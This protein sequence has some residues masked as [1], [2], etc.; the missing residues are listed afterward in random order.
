MEI[1]P[2]DEKDEVVEDEA[3]WCGRVAEG[4]DIGWGEME[5]MG[6]TLTGGKRTVEGETARRFRDV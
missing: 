4:V 5:D 3:V 6:E 2:E 1:E